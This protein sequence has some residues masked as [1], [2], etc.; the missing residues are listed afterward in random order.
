MRWTAILRAAAIS[1]TAASVSSTVALTLLA[2]AAGR[3][4]TQPVN[5]TSHWLHGDRAARFEGADLAHTG[6]GYA[7]HHAATLFWST[8]FETW[9]GDRRLAP[10]PMLQHAMAMSAIAAVVDYAAT[11]HRFTPGWELVL[12]KGDMAA[13]YV[14]MALGLAAGSLAARGTPPRPR[15][16]AVSG[17]A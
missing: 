5:A 4:P 17:P 2:R 10:L 6:V 8:I 1:G 16:A 13:A 7:T 15:S 14:A 12:S 9:L 11:P 3:S